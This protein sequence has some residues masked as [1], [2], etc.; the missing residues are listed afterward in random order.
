MAS[1]SSPNDTNKPEPQLPVLPQLPEN[2]QM[3][4]LS[5][6]TLLDGPFKTAFELNIETLMKYE[7]DRL[8]APFLKE[9]GLTPKGQLY[10]NW[11]GLDGHVT[12]HYLSALAIT[13]AASENDQVWERM[14]YMLDELQLCQDKNGDG[15]LGG[16]PNGADLWNR[17]KRGDLSTLGNYWVPW[18]NIHKIFAGLRD[19]WTYCG[20]EQGRDM[21]LQLCDWGLGIIENLDDE[22]M[23]KML[24]TEFGGMNEVYIDAYEM[25]GDTKYLDAAKRFS[26]KFLLDSM[27]SKIDNLNGQHANTQVPKVV[28]YAKV[29]KYTND[30]YYTTAADFFWDRVVN[31]RSVAFGGNSRNERFR[32]PLENYLYMEWVQGPE[33]CN[34][35]NML[36]LT[37][38]LFR[39]KPQAKYADYYERALYNHILSSQN[40]QTGGYVYFTPLRPEHYRI[41][42][43]ANVDMWCCVGTGMENHGKYG[44]FI[45]ARDNDNNDL[46]VNL[47][48]ASKL[49]WDSKGVT[50]TQTTAFPDEESSKL[51]VNVKSPARL[52]IK[53]RRP[54]WIGSTG[55]KVQVNGEEKN[56]ASDS[57]ADTYIEIDRVWND[58]D[59]VDI[60]LPM[61]IYVEGIANVSGVMAIMRGPILLSAKVDTESGLRMYGDGS[62]MGHEANGLQIA[63]DK[64]PVII[65]EPDE[66]L[67]KLKDMEATDDGFVVPGLSS[68]G[69]VVLKPFFRLHD[70]RYIMYWVAM[71]EEEYE[72]LQS[73]EDKETE[74][75]NRTV[76][77][78]MPG[79][80][81]SEAG[82]NLRTSGYVG[83]GVLN[84]EYYRSTREGG[85]FQ[86]DMDTQ[87]EQNLTLMVR[88]WGNEIESRTFDIL[89]GG[90][91]LATE[92]TSGKWKVDEFKNVEYPIPAAMLQGKSTITVRFQ[93]S[94]SNQTGGVYHIRLLK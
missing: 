73:H 21:F 94:G 65:G 82:H 20:N 10:S 22:K 61:D 68:E 24:D 64:A 57:K 77:R 1:C 58:G 52:R 6:V 66:I 5:S 88:Y 26:H 85:W 34:T 92:N 60:K 51:T 86:Y 39:I 28:G 71:T 80:Q 83:T 44:E 87:G 12:G 90:T 93:T 69:D 43:T 3:F 17:I 25:T 33:T 47:F 11:S 15:Y 49:S 67:A 53:I 48:A 40:P 62:R 35:Y 14:T 38:T 50:L 55:M 16:V 75:A 37:E 70:S 45:Y 41:Y 29:A 63:T 91:K 32:D 81:Q 2:V 9:A 89:I 59:R 74:L 79:E 13:W 19:T 27:A 31:Y 54:W 56:Y 23:E 36:K 7:T 46:Y 78:V 30:S 8:L 18:Y 42:S 4:P 76:D 72:Q 84:G